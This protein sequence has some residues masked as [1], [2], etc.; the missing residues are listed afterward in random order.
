MQILRGAWAEAAKRARALAILDADDNALI[1][2]RGHE[3]WPRLRW[4]RYCQ[5]VPMRYPNDQGGARR[6]RRV[7][8][9]RSA[10]TG[11]GPA[12]KNQKSV[13]GAL[14]CVARGRNCANCDRV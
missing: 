13:G 4:Y 1:V 8:Y 9:L 11:E 6:H 12:G 7:R 5:S 2:F 14:G 10:R 3:P